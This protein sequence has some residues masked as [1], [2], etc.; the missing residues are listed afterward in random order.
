MIE[1][2][3]MLGFAAIALLMVLTPG[4]N[5]LYLISRSIC[6]GKKA[7]WISLCGVA[8]GFVFYM[9][10]AAM[11]LTALLFTVPFAYDA[12]RILGAIYL[13]WLAWQAISPK[14]QSVFQAIRLQADSPLKLF[15]MGFLTNLLNP[16]IAMM[17]LSLLPQF[18]RPEQGSVFAQSLQLG[19]LQILISIAVNSLIVYSAGSIALFLNQKP[20]WQKIQK[21]MMGTVLTALALRMLA[22]QKH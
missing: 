6:Q 22:E 19:T 21:W 8:L 10:C 9:F 15:L 1:N 14:S 2:T 13:L 3:S 18:I 17:Y 11:G 20:Q 12:I 4:P 16:K 7:G 5:M